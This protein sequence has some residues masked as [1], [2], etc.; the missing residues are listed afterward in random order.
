MEMDMAT[1]QAYT[2]VGMATNQ[3]YTTVRHTGTIGIS[4][5]SAVYALPAF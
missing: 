3:T 2:T 5:D 1:N 4:E